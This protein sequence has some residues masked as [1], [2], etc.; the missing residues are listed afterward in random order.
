MPTPYEGLY[1]TQA[2]C[3]EHAQIMFPMF[4]VRMALELITTIIITAITYYAFTICQAFR[5]ALYLTEIKAVS[6]LLSKAST[7]ICT[8]HSTPS[9]FLFLDFSFSNGSSLLA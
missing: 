1:S 6:L 3:S 8:L 2:L 5:Y 4:K 9:N 7:S